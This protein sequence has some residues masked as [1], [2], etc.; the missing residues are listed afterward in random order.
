MVIMVVAISRPRNI[1]PA[2]PMMIRA[3]LK[4]CGRNPAQIPTVTAHTSGAMFD[5]S[6]SPALNN[7]SAYRKIAAPAMSTIPAAR[8]SSPSMRLIALA[9]TTTVSTVTSGGEVGREHDVLVAR[10][11]HA[12]VQ[13]RDAEH[14]QHAAAQDLARDLRGRRH[15]AEVVDRA[16][17]EHHR[18][19]EQ[20][21]ERLGVVVE[22]L[23]ELRD[24]RRHRE[25]DE[26]PDEH[27][28]ATE[29]RQ[30][31]GVHAARPR[32]RDRA[33]ARRDPP[34]GERQEERDDGRD[35][36]DDEISPQVTTSLSDEFRVGRECGAERVGLGLHVG[37]HVLVV[38]PCAA[39]AR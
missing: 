27:R 3:G 1:A 24:L 9:I 34:H 4:L 17:H 12:E 13:Q 14:R 16:D 39:P 20:Q 26:E 21:T 25:R 8:P 18:A 2:S 35:A 31:L 28:G 7:R 15:G 5:P 33:D 22:H 30:R 10:E 37:R 19:R 6:S 38:R 23:L 32:H 29:R 36:A 11:R